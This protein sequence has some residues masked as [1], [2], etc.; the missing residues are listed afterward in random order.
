MALGI[1]SLSVAG[2]E[3]K[4]AD[5]PV[6]NL[7]VLFDSALSMAPHVTSIVSS[8]NY[9]LRNVSHARD[10]MS[11]DA[12]RTLVQSLV[13]S[14]LDYCNVLLLNISA[15][16]ASKLQTVLNNAARLVTRTRKCEHITPVLIEL[17]WLPV[18]ACVEFKVLTTV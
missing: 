15:E 17:H 11:K 14:R 4:V 2:V 12:A 16:L 13:I 9:H 10:R 1:E 8:A 5:V 6:R 3:V 18:R 7:G